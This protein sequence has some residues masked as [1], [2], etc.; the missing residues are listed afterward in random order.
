MIKV[1]PLRNGTLMFPVHLTRQ[2]SWYD[3]QAD[4]VLRFPVKAPVIAFST[5]PDTQHSRGHRE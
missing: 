1:I 5:K 3:R 2:G 4:N